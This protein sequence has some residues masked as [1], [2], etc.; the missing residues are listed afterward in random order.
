MA[1]C[2]NTLPFSY[3][4]QR[5]VRIAAAITA[6]GC[7][8]HHDEIGRMSEPQFRGCT[9]QPII[10]ER[11]LV[12]R[13]GSPPVLIR[14]HA[15]ELGAVWEGQSWRCGYS[16]TGYLGSLRFTMESIRAR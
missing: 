7:D 8:E 12:Y 6:L 5:W 2:R 3:M 15:P 11:E 9:A 4:P 14:L 13:G 16:V 1:L 10:A